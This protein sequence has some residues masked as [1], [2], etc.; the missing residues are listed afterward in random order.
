M[1]T[2][3]CIRAKIQSSS[4]SIFSLEIIDGEG[5]SKIYK[6]LTGDILSLAHFV[7]LINEGN[8]SPLHIEEM[9]EDFLP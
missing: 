7:N 3:N 9:I 4:G 1:I 6:D 5:N 8:V 2:K